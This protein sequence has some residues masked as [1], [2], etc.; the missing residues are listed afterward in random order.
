MSQ[1]KYASL[2]V[3]LTVAETEHVLGAVLDGGAHELRNRA[4]LLVLARVGVRACEL[5]HLMLDDIDWVKGCIRVRPGKSHRE[6][7]LPS[8]CEVGEALCT[9]PEFR[10]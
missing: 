5:T 10:V 9:Y 1:W 6:R 2:P 3:H 4:M 8:P 7:R